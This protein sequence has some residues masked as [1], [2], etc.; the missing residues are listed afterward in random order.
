MFR[1]VR[2]E[3]D[4]LCR[5]EAA[6][7]VVRDVAQLVR[8][9]LRT[10]DYPVDIAVRMSVD[11]VFD[12]A[13]FDEAVQIRDEGAVEWA[14]Q[15]LRVQQLEAGQVVRHHDDMCCRAAAYG[16]V[17]EVETNCVKKQIK[18]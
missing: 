14:A 10:A 17:Q 12:G 18:R 15:K 11:P 7:L 6:V 4:R 1:H 13:G 5:I 3:Y 16:V 9:A 2:S 8:K